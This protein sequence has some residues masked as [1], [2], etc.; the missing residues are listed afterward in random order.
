MR[1]RIICGHRQHKHLIDPLKS[2]HHHLP[3]PAHSLGPAKALFDKLSLLLRDSVAACLCNGVGHCRASVRSVLRHM[4]RDFHFQASGHE[5]LLVIALVCAQR[6][7]GFRIAR[8]LAC[9]MDHCLG[10]F[11]LSVPVGPGHH[12]VGDQSMTVVRQGMAYKA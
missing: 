2:A 3:N 10:R 1:I 4:L 8:C 7:L 5:F 6:D 11:S 9:I 12:G